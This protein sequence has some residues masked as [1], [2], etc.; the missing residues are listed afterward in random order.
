M[1]T[2]E[3]AQEKAKRLIIKQPGIYVLFG[4]L[5]SKRT[6]VTKELVHKTMSWMVRI[7]PQ[8]K[9][10][11][12]MFFEECKK[13]LCWRCMQPRAIAGSKGSW[14]AYGPISEKFY[15]KT[16][17]RDIWSDVANYI[18]DKFPYT[19]NILRIKVVV[20]QDRSRTYLNTTEY[21]PWDTK[22]LDL[23][24]TAFEDDFQDDEIEEFD[25]EDYLAAQEEKEQRRAELQDPKKQKRITDF[26]G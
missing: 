25:Y 19:G 14:V 23:F 6:E 13:V 8:K 11:Q 10:L 12:K 5:H 15:Q 24:A 4:M 3:S 17:S 2:K 18:D 26:F 21:R 20:H 9:T 7:Y 22:M 16:H 1:S